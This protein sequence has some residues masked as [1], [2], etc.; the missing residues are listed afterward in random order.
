MS[1][2]NNIIRKSIVEGS[3]PRQ[4]HQ[5]QQRAIR[6]L[7]REYNCD[8]MPHRRRF[9]TY[10]LEL[11]EHTYHNARLIVDGHKVVIE[12]WTPG[13][14]EATSMDEEYVREADAIFADCR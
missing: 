13:V 4:R 5:Q 6:S 7:T 10:L 14:N 8:N 2:L 9:V 1:D 12:A 3:V 11:Q